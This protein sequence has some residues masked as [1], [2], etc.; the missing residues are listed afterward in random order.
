M[1]VFGCSTGGLPWFMWL[2]GRWRPCCAQPARKAEISKIQKM[3]DALINVLEKQWVFELLFSTDEN[4]EDRE[5]VSSIIERA[6]KRLRSKDS[7][8]PSA[9]RNTIFLWPASN[10]CEKCPSIA[11]HAMMNRQNG[12]LPVNFESQL[13]LYMNREQWGIDDLR[14]IVN[15]CNSKHTSSEA[16]VS[17]Y[18]PS[19]S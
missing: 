5:A 3:H 1:G 11:G 12:T 7:T 2:C 10:L 6:A 19:L 15:W 17:D 16:H 14:K 4:G 9:Y 18:F 13:F 8:K